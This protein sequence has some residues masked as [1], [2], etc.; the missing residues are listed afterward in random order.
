MSNNSWGQTLAVLKV[1]GPNVTNTTS[2]TSLLGSGAGQDARFNL[3]SNFLNVG[4]KLRI[5]FAGTIS[6]AASSP[7]TIQ[8]SVAIGSVT[9]YT[10]TV[11]PTLTTSMSGVGFRGVIDLTCV[12]VGGGTNASINGNGEFVGAGMAS[13]LVLAPAAGGGFDST[14]S[15]FV[16]LFA[17]WS[18]A[19]ASNII[20]LAAGGYELLSRN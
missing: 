7:G 20:A 17:T 5:L 13:T 14:A 8:L 3:P 10:G 16:D 2:A 6:S 9:V 18:V 12:A 11:S 4:S 15:G 19:S 1:A